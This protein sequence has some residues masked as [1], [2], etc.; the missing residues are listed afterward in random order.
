M[1]YRID[2][3]LLKTLNLRRSATNRG[4]YEIVI[5]KHCNIAR[6]SIERYA[7]NCPDDTALV[8]EREDQSICTWTFAELE[9]DASRLAHN[10]DQLGVNRG[11]RVALHTGMRPETGIALRTSRRPSSGVRARYNRKT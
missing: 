1:T 7:L 10:L 6:N 4:G 8:F 11:D 9:R 5:P 2:D 3:A